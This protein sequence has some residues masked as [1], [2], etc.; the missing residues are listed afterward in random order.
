MNLGM[1]KNNGHKKSI[2]SIFNSY[3]MC[4]VETCMWLRLSQYDH[5]KYHYALYIKIPIYY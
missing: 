1:K 2:K 3:N 4:V 5:N